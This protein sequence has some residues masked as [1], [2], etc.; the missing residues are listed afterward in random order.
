[1][2][3]SNALSS[4]SRST[5]KLTTPWRAPISRWASGNS[6]SAS[7][8]SAPS[9]TPSGKS[10]VR[11]LPAGNRRLNADRGEAASTQADSSPR[12]KCQPQRN[13]ASERSERSDRLAGGE[14]FREWQHTAEP[15]AV[16][17]RNQIG[18]SQRPR[19]SK[20]STLR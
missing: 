6:R 12:L 13:L 11:V 1:K 2:A 18:G 4:S 8:R 3:N 16:V 17:G 5:S 15:S 14:E 19:A 20:A 10:P 7:F 9:S